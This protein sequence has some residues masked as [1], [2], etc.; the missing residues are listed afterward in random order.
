MQSIVNTQQAEAWNGPEG[1]HWAQNADRYDAM[2]AG[3]ND[4]LLAAAGIGERDRVLDVGCGTGGPTRL[5]ARQASGGD[6]TG[7]DISAP[8]LDRARAAAAE[9]GLTNVSFVQGDAEVYPFPADHYD[10]AISR[11]GVMFFGDHVAAFNNIWQA[12]RPGGRLVFAGPQ[13]GGTSS[14]HT[15]AFAP[16]GPLMRGP[17]PA[18][19]GMGSLTDPAR[20]Q[21]ILTVA[22]FADVS[23]TPVEVPV[24]WGRDAGDAVDFYFATG[25]VRHNLAD[26][27]AAT[28]Q[29]VRDEVRSALREYETPD[30]VN[31]AGGIWLVTATRRGAAGY[32]R[33]LPE[34]GHVS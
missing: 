22:G 6:V 4:P 25:P 18:A 32:R 7:I 23:V 1:V 19:R 21:E 17:S 2:A 8:M 30:G 28:V 5:A 15:R 16:L 12:L 34:A 13:P 11:G 33:V 31:L 24:V 14:D 10:L 3:I 27:D 26:V 29:R 20:I 9:E